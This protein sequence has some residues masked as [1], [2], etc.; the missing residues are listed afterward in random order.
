MHSVTRKQIEQAKE[1]DLLSY[2]QMYEH[3]ELKKCGS[4]YCTVSHDSLKI[5]NGKWHWH[6]QGVGGRTALDYLIKVK[7][8]DFV[9]AV[10]TLCGIGSKPIQRTGK[11][12][13]RAAPQCL[14]E[15]PLCPLSLPEPNRYGTAMV[16]YLQ[17]RGVDADIISRCIGLGI[18]YE[19]RRYHNCVFIGRDREGKARYACIRGIG[20]RYR[21]E[22]E[23]S[24]KRYGFC[25]RSRACGCFSVTVAESPI[26][27][28][29]VA[30]VRKIQGEDWEADNYLSLGGTA[31]CALLQFLED[32]P[33]IERITLCLDNDKAGIRGMEKIHE[34]ILESPGLSRRTL[35]IIDS[36]PPVSCGKDY[37]DLLQKRMAGEP[38][39]G[40][41]PWQL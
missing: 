32:H 4:E 15:E 7:R 20:G 28:L 29:S 34:A 19:G 9:K 40:D 18:L 30:S 6:S 41:V 31:P 38:G 35:D 11:D 39:R 33:A 24:D 1:W 8:M 16:S 22:V 26:D 36:P 25:L 37:N 12:A 3:Q 5:S 21:G 23:G 14:P 17:G 2:L 27:A 13:C 10:E